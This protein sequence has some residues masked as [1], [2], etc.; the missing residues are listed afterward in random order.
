MIVCLS[1]APK[2]S[3]RSVTGLYSS[4]RLQSAISLSSLLFAPA[5]LLSRRE[6]CT[7]LLPFVGGAYYFVSSTLFAPDTAALLSQRRLSLL[8]AL[9]VLS[10]RERVIQSF[11]SSEQ[12]T[13][14][15]F[16]RSPHNTTL[17]PSLARLSVL[18]LSL[19]L[20]SRLFFAASWSS[21]RCRWRYMRRIVKSCW[22]GC[23][24]N[25]KPPA[26]TPPTVSSFCR[27]GR[28]KIG[29]VQITFP[30]SGRKATLCT[31]LE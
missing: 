30:S 11:A 31:C 3:Q 26:E 29:T 15:S 13:T 22:I 25:W 7:V 24:R 6:N 2:E 8:L 18:S 28:S 9:A 19:P 12:E 17:C 16:H 14:S 10:R 1:V 23:G 21:C 5:V 27:V 20:F 4:G